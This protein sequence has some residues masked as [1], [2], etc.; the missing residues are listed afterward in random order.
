M[1]N[2]CFD[3][4]PSVRTYKMEGVLY[5]CMHALKACICRRILLFMWYVHVSMCCV[6]YVCICMSAWERLNIYI[7]VSS[8][9]YIYIYIYSQKHS[10]VSNIF[11]LILLFPCL[12][13]ES[14]TSLLK[15]QNWEAWKASLR[16]LGK[17]SKEAAV[18]VEGRQGFW[19]K[20]WCCRCGESVCI[21][22][23]LHSSVYVCVCIVCVWYGHSICIS[24]CPSCECLCWCDRNAYWCGMLHAW[25]EGDATCWILMV[26]VCSKDLGVLFLLHMRFGPSSVH[27]YRRSTCDGVR[28]YLHRQ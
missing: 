17:G 13:C 3:S 6:H 27:M 10:P 5:S 8:Y 19:V 14:Q 9:I 12:L 24:V 4:H 15:K 22:G 1:S 21:V 26:M 16:V 25:G 23:S 28:F 11:W 2:V 18:L 7:S 20:R